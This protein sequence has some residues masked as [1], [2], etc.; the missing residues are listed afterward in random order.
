MSSTS[1]FPIYGRMAAVIASLFFI[2]AF[3]SCGGGRLIPRD[4]KDYVSAKLPT[5]RRNIDVDQTFQ[6]KII[7]LVEQMDFRAAGRAEK[8]LIRKCVEY[9][10]RDNITDYIQDTLVFHVRLKTDVDVYIRWTAPAIDMRDLVRERI[11][12]ERF[13]EICRREESWDWEP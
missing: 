2:F 3:S 7:L 12:E 11:T 4:L 8:D 1:R 9:F 13:F 6:L 10:R 5:P